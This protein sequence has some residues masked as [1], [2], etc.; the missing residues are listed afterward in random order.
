MTSDIFEKP[1]QPGDTRRPAYDA[2]DDV[3]EAVARWSVAA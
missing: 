1:R 3:N 2:L